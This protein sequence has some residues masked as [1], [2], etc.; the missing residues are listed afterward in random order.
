[1]SVSN[2]YAALNEDLSLDEYT[3]LDST[4]RSDTVPLVPQD[5]S[6]PDAH[7]PAPIFAALSRIGTGLVSS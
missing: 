6:T 2:S 5:T 3:E 1:M 7:R 4:M